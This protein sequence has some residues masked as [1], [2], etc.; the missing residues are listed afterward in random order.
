[1]KLNLPHQKFI[2]FEK[3]RRIYVS[4][5]MMSILLLIRF[6]VVK[7]S[8]MDIL[9][10]KYNIIFV[11][12]TNGCFYFVKEEIVV[13]IDINYSAH[14][15]LQKSIRLHNYLFIYLFHVFGNTGWAAV[16]DISIILIVDLLYC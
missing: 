12:I 3:A 8:K 9:L 5:K 4:H 2:P 13:R 7:R 6:V 16:G 15:L 14:S 10:K 1:M 11:Q